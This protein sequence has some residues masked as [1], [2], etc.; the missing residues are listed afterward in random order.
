MSACGATLTRQTCIKDV[1]DLD[2]FS[3][4]A[5]AEVYFVPMAGQWLDNNAPPGKDL[6]FGCGDALSGDYLDLWP[7]DHDFSS[8][9]PDYVLVI[10]ANRNGQGWRY[11][12]VQEAAEAKCVCT[13]DMVPGMQPIQGLAPEES[14]YEPADFEPSATVDQLHGFAITGSSDFDPTDA[15]YGTRIAAFFALV[16]TVGVLSI[17]IMWCNGCCSSLSCHRNHC[18]CCYRMGKTRGKILTITVLFLSA[19]TMLGSYGGRSAF[20]NSVEEMST[21]MRMTADIFEVIE[22]QAE[23][24]F[25]GGAEFVAN[26]ETSACDGEALGS[27]T[28]SMLVTQAEAFYTAAEGMYTLVCP[29]DDE[30]CDDL[31]EQCERTCLSTT[32]YDGADAFEDPEAGMPYYVDLGIMALTA[33]CWS[34]AFL[35]VLAACT[36]CVWDDIIMNIIAAVVLLIT[37]VFCGFLVSISI[38]VADFCAADPGDTLVTVAEDAGIDTPMIPYYAQCE[39]VNPFVPQLN[40]TVIALENLNNT[41]LILGSPIPFANLLTGEMAQTEPSC[42]PEA[43][44]GLHSFVHTLMGAVVEIGGL[45]ECDMINPLVKQITDEIICGGVL[46]GIYN[47]WVVLLVSAWLMWLAFIFMPMSSHEILSP[48]RAAAK[49][50]RKAKKAGNG[51]ATNSEAAA[52]TA[53][54]VT[55]ELGAAPSRKPG[56]ASI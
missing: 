46:T 4:L 45:F 8:L 29:L 1:A 3:R 53:T 11:E 41:I 56:N 52:V 33:A 32:V 5:A 13:T 10:L 27:D 36:N 2:T 38:A 35:S 14:S 44:D 9:P 42:S 47:M 25:S 39:G 23:V 48:K 34:L 43:M 15:E 30:D 31:V 40:E 20:H 16:V 49:A 18:A 37:V 51:P 54:Q 26:A 21:L 24:M 55:L 6:Y 28:T 22:T 17:I 19:G 12:Q 7:S 50:A